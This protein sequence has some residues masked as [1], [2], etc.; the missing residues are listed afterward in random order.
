MS[1]HGNGKKNGPMRPNQPAVPL[2]Q[3][4]EM[5]EKDELE[6]FKRFLASQGLGPQN[7]AQLLRQLCDKGFKGSDEFQKVGLILEYLE[8]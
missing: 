8:Q 7:A 2:I 4:S 6:N 5:M 1:N 3:L